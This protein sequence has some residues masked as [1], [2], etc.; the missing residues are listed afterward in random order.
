MKRIVIVDSRETVK[1]GR[2]GNLTRPVTVWGDVPHSALVVLPT[3]LQAELPHTAFTFNELHRNCR[4]VLMWPG[5]GAIRRKV[6][7]RTYVRC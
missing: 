5:Q 1:T 7:Q 3:L 4:Y 6:R 2:S